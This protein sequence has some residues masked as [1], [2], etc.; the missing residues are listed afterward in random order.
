MVLLKVYPKK[1]T[2]VPKLVRPLSELEI[3]KAKPKDK[4]YKLFDGDG[5]FLLV[6]PNGLKRKVHDFDPN[7]RLY[8]RLDMFFGKM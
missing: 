1:G 2:K 7:Y 8:L 4:Q 3:K 6:F 5:L